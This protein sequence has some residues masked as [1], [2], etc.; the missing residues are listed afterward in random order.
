M[1]AEYHAFA[2]ISLELLWPCRLLQEMG[3][4]FASAALL[5]YD[6]RSVIQITHND[7]I[8]EQIKHIDIDIDCHF[9]YYHVKSGAI[10]LCSISSIDQIV[11]IFTKFAGRGRGC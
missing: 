11:D 7:V 8:H 4:R 3:V 6:N 1:G 2:D 9:I 10:S 5:Y